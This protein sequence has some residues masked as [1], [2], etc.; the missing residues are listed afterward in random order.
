MQPAESNSP[1]S[2]SPGELRAALGRAHDEAARLLAAEDSAP[3]DIVAWL[4]A[5]IAAYEHV[6]YPVIKHSLPNGH[7]LVDADRA[8]VIRL[9]RA[10]RV[11]ERHHSGDTLAAGLSPARLD[12]RITELIGQHQELQA[13]ILA[14]LEGVLDSAGLDKLRSAYNSA[15]QHAPTR[16]HP[17]LSSGGMVFRLDALRD[18]ILDTMDSRHVPIPK[19]ARTR[20]IPGRWGSWL[21]GQPQPESDSG[22]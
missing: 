20:I 15:L 1:L 14:K 7:A 2:D 10:L 5:H 3:L 19:V 17:H 6:V 18:R 21:L 16:P 22:K 4:S 13:S 12:A 9:A 8:I 11:K